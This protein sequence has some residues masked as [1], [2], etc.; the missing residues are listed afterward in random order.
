M[1][2]YKYRMSI[3]PMG[4][5]VPFAGRLLAIDPHGWLV[6]DIDADLYEALKADPSKWE[7]H[8]PA[9]PVAAE[10]KPIEPPEMSAP[11][12]EADEVG[13]ETAA[14]SEDSEPVKPVKKASRSRRRSKKSTSKQDD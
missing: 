9:A 14:E 7:Y 5:N 1:W 6:S 4:F 3:A 2:K 13:G 11:A 10:P 12:A 8:P